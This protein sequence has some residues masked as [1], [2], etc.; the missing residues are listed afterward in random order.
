MSDLLSFPKQEATL[1]SSCPHYKTHLAAAYDTPWSEQD[2]TSK[3]SLTAQSP[4]QG[5]REVSNQ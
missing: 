5:G 1:K 2:P 4:H 3:E